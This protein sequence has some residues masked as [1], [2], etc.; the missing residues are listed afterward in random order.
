MVLLNHHHI[1]DLTTPKW[2]TR[3]NF[4]KSDFFIISFNFY[5]K[6]FCFSFRFSKTTK[7]SQITWLFINHLKHLVD[8][9]KQLKGI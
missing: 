6:Y 4:Y 2:G 8:K 1:K 9:Y 3:S 5:L 7:S